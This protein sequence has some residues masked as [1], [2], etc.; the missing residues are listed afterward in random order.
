[1]YAN[2][3]VMA[4]LLRLVAYESDDAITIRS[5]DLR[6]KVVKVHVHEWKWI[7]RSAIH[8]TPDRGC[9]EKVWPNIPNRAS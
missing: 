2:M 7:S 8:I 9:R 3:I 1:M 6:M 4:N 5:R